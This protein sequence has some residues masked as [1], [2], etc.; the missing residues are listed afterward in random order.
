MCRTPP[1][2]KTRRRRSSSG[3]RPATCSPPSQPLVA[4]SPDG[5]TLATSED[6]NA[7][8]LWDV[9]YTEDIA[10]RLCASAGRPL[11]R[12]EWAQY[13][14]PGPAYENPMLV[15]AS[16]QSQ[17][18]ACHLRSLHPQGT[19]ASRLEHSPCQQRRRHA[20]NGDPP[21]RRRGTPDRV[22]ST[23][24][25]R[26]W[27]LVPQPISRPLPAHTRRSDF[28]SKVGKGSAV[29]PDKISKI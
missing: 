25:R 26:I 16:Q 28:L 1:P 21:Q 14:P 18:P 13:V 24:N 8:R 9:A 6:D 5:K 17:E 10:P 23:Q 2:S 15:K 19:P 4:F 27:P 7:V 12:A 20:G 29:I 11:T 3:H 22:Q